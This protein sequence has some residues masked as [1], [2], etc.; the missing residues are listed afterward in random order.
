[1]LVLV[2]NNYLKTMCAPRA[3]LSLRP[4]NLNI[5]NGSFKSLW[6]LPSSWLAPQQQVCC[7]QSDWHASVSGLQR[8]GRLRVQGIFESLF[9]FR[10][11]WYLRKLSVFGNWHSVQQCSHRCHSVI[12]SDSSLRPWTW[13]LQCEC[14]QSQLLSHTWQGHSKN[15]ELE[16]K[17]KNLTDCGS[18]ASA[19]KFLSQWHTKSHAHTH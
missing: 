16:I 7:S 8:I 13:K 6:Q 12:H 1:M 18:A 11:Q 10:S 9:K 2:G 5:W 4:A 3:W 19:W 15:F 17:R 14:G